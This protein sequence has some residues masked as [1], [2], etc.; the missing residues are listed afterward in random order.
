MKT[1]KRM[2]LLVAMMSV[3]VL[4]GYAEKD[5]ATKEKQNPQ[6]ATTVN[7]QTPGKFVDNDKNGVCDN[8]QSGVQKRQGQNFTDKNGDGTCDNRLNARNGAGNGKGCGQGRQF[9]GGQGS[10][11][12]R[13][14][15]CQNRK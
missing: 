12:C 5:P 14:N 3:L 2:T 7:A 15:G 8:R 6:K 11:N 9:R 13:G 10:G 1:L 4:Q